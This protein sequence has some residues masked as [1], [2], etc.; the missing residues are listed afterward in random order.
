M[1]SNLPADNFEYKVASS[2]MYI[3]DLRQIYFIFYKEKIY[4]IEI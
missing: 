2:T 1:V 3:P 4:Y